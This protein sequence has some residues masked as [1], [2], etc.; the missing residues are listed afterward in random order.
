M[1]KYEPRTMVAKS[2]Y[3]RWFPTLPAEVRADVYA[4]MEELRQEEAEYCDKGNYDHMAQ[5]LMSIAVYEV[6]QAHG[7][8]EEE[9][10][11][12]VS[13]NMWA[14]LDPSDE[15]HFECNECIYAKILGRRGLLKLGG[16]VLPRRRHQLRRA[17]LHRLHPH[18]DALPGR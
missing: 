18:A 15:F 17:T 10:F 12:A 14:F 4:R 11:A 1:E 3:Q 7:A 16:H 6:L 9:A 5:I 2:R 8:S 13:E